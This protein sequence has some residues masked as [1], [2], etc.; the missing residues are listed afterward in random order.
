MKI[1]I[2]ENTSMGGEKYRLFDKLLLTSFSIFPTLYARQI[3]AIT[4]K[5]HEVKFLNERYEKIDFEERY[6]IVNINFTTSTAK[7]AYE[8]ADKFRERGITVV[9]S[10][11]HPSALPEEAKKHADSVLIGRG[12]LGWLE[13]LKDFENNQLKPFYQH[14]NYEKDTSLPPIDIKTPGLYLTGAIEATRGCPYRCAFCQESNIPGGSNYF[15]RA[16]DEVISEIKSIPQKTIVFYDSSL[17][18]DPSYSKEL[19]K[20]MKGLRKK[21]F[22]NGNVDILARDE[23]LVK[24]SKEA[25]CI[26]WL[27]GFESI[28]ED[29]I[30]LIN[31]KTNK[32]EYY[33]KAVDNIHKNKMAVVGDFVFGFD[34]DTP[35][36]FDK[37]LDM[38]K[39]LEIDAADFSILTPFPGT[40]IYS[41]LESEN[42]I[43]TKDWSLYNY[44]NVVFKP[45]NMTPEQLLEGVRKMYI[46]FYSTRYTLKRLRDAINLGFYPFL[47]VLLRNAISGMNSRRLRKLKE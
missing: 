2:V 18:I 8:I 17:T 12:E 27:I 15:A 24:L 7:R 3:A 20:K 10:G 21:F 25:G 1:L 19:F 36:I 35:D 37:T 32:V 31:K 16:I 45:K 14:V 5:R 39:E 26:S 34:T 38:I 13:L 11:L 42:R 9:L 41:K 6:D 43:I 46:E 22:C 29:T 47:T 44:G 30:D 23:E 40:P 33:K 28:S 4:P